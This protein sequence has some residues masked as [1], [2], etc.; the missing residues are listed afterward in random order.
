MGVKLYFCPESE[1]S[2]INPPI[3]DVNIAIPFIYCNV[4]DN[5]CEYSFVV[6]DIPADTPILLSIVDIAAPADAVNATT[7]ASAPNSK[8]L[9]INC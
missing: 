6:P 9:V 1:A 8:L 7:F 4:F 3:V 5:D 2:Y